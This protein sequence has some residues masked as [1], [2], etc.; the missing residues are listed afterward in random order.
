MII[1]YIIASLLTGAGFG[2]LDGLINAN[3]IATGL[4]QAYKPIA[5]IRINFI[6]GISADLVYG[7]I[8]AG[9]FIILYKSLPGSSGIVKGISFGIL[10]WFFR[11]LMSAASTF[12]MFEIPVPTI[13]YQLGTGLGE[14]LF[15]GIV[16][17]LVLNNIK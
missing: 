13:L 1:R 6:F 7:F 10:A 16:L 3:P 15:L 5:K 12:V 8:A 17:G 4:Y 9:V 2:F 11:V 14:M